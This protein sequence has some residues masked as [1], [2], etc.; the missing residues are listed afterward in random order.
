MG[1]LPDLNFLA[2][3]GVTFVTTTF[4][5]HALDPFAGLVQVD[6]FSGNR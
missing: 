4:Y 3:I 6:V 2:F 5:E 1:R